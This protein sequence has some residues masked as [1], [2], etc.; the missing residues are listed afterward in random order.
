MTA[1]AIVESGMTFGPYPEGRCF[2]IE[3]SQ[4]YQRIKNQGVKVA[5]FLLLRQQQKREVVWVVEAKPSSPRMFEGKPVSEEEKDKAKKFERFIS[6]IRDKFTNSFLITVA[7]CLQRHPQA[8]DDLSGQFKKLN[9]QSQGISF[10]LVINGH[11]ESWLIPIKDALNI[12]LR[13]LVKTWGLPNSSVQ[14]LNHELAQ[15]YGLI[16]SAP[17]ETP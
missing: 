17:T 15:K 8:V 13:P 3:K 2:Y 10:V 16:L 9:L 7:A 14:V 11:Q 12:A 1:E 4:C 5:E 6:E